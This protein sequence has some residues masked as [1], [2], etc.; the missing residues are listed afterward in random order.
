MR[1]VGHH[2]ECLAIYP[3]SAADVLGPAQSPTARCH[4]MNALQEARITPRAIHNPRSW[5]QRLGLIMHYPHSQAE[6]EQYIQIQVQQ[7]FE[8]IQ[9]EFLKRHLT[10]SI[11]SLEDG[12]RLKV[13]HQ[14]EINFIYQVVSRETVPPSFMP[15]VTADAPFYQAEVF[16][17][18]GGQ[19]YDVMDWTQEDLLQDILDQYERH[20][21][22]LSIVRSPE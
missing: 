4:Q 15:E 1:P 18:E 22:F 12:L 2:Y 5:Q 9:K 21:Y 11:D 14:H 19:N 7:A 16:L 6:V 3:H 20:L 10:V 13:D 8:N 17:R